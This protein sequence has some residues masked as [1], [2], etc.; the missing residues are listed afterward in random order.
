[1][2]RRRTSFLYQY[3]MY[4]SDYCNTGNY[5]FKDVHKTIGFQYI[6]SVYVNF[7]RP[8]TVFT[9]GLR[10]KCPIQKC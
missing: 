7:N 3:Y 4:N 10:L 1:M 6:Y 2:G 5:L 8:G 9:K